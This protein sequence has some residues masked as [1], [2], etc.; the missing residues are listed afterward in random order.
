MSGTKGKAEQEARA[1]LRVELIL[2]VLNKQMTASAAAK[3]MGISRKSYYKWEKRALVG[4]EEAAGERAAGRPRM[5]TDEEKE[6]LKRQVE[7]L[8]KEVTV[9]KQTLQIRE[10]LQPTA[11]RNRGR[12]KKPRRGKRRRMSQAELDLKSGAEPGTGG[13]SGY[14]PSASLAAEGH[15]EGL[16]SADEGDTM[17]EGVQWGSDEEAGG[18]S[19]A[20]YG[21]EKKRVRHDR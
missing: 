5:E 20:E 19:E 13:V 1:R 3:Q 18:H 16:G 11:E 9:L 12:P 10:L 7:A 2:K 15:P 6:A 14:G 4:L 8:E 21:L 17:P